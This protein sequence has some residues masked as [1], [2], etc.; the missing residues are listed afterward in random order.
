MSLL[1][2]FALEQDAGLA[3][4]PQAEPPIR[5]T[6]F[7]EN[8]AAGFR[9]DRAGPDMGSNN[10]RYTFDV[11]GRIADALRQRG[12]SLDNYSVVAARLNRQ[13]LARGDQPDFLAMMSV[14]ADGAMWRA[15]AAERKKDPAFLADL[16]DVRDLDSLDRHVVVARN[17]DLATAE[18]VQRGATGLGKAGAL[19]GGLGG[20]LTKPETF[21]PIGGGATATASVGRQILSAAVREAAANAVVTVVG[22]PL[23]GIDAERL[24][25][26]RTMGDFAADVAMS[27]GA[28]AVLGGGLK[29]VEIGARRLPGAVADTREALLGRYFDSLP[30]SVQRRMLEAGTLDQRADAA[31]V[32]ELLGADRLTPDERAAVHVLNY[33]ADVR[34]SS[35]FKPSPE[36]DKLHGQRLA[37]AID[38]LNA[39]EPLPQFTPTRRPA[40]GSQTALSSNKRDIAARIIMAESGGKAT[41]RNPVPGQSASG[42]GQF[43][44]E[45]W[46]SGIKKWFPAVARGKTD[47]Q[48]LALKTDPLLGRQ[49]TERA[50]EEYGRVLGRVGLPVTADNAY[51]IH[52]LGPRRGLA[53][54]HAPAVVEVRRL[55]PADVI[56]AN[57]RVLEGKTVGDVKAWA[58]QQMGQEAPSHLDFA[59][60]AG[61]G[62]ELRAEQFHDDGERRA[63]E[64]VLYGSDRGPFGPIHRDLAGDWSATVERLRTAG[65]GEVP[66][67][68]EHPEVGPIDVIWG[69]EKGG[70]RHVIEKHPEIVA[71]LP[72][73]LSTM[74]VV[75]R[76]PNRIQ[77]ADAEHHAT[78]RL[79]Y[80]GEQ[81]SWLLTA[82]RRDE[83]PARAEDRRAGAGEQDGS[84]A[85]GAARNIGSG[86]RRGKP[87]RDEGPTDL[88]TQIARWGGVRNDEGHDLARTGGLGNRMTRGG[89]VLTRNGLSIDQLGERL[90]EAGWFRERPEVADVL[91]LIDEAVSLGKLYRPEDRPIVAERLRALDDGSDEI[92][93]M[94]SDAARLQGVDPDP[95]LL[96]DAMA[97]MRRGEDA[98]D[99]LIGAINGRFRDEMA[100]SADEGVATP[101]PAGMM[102]AADWNRVGELRDSLSGWDDP[103]GLA[104]VDQAMSIEHDLRM[105]LEAEGDQRFLL[106][107]GGDDRSLGQILDDADKDAAAADA[108]RACLTPMN[109]AV[110]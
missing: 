36:A 57:R 55:L 31:I 39:G 33:D 25:I 84:P 2:G 58:A 59:P 86:R 97:R 45:T 101:D 38:A 49:M 3:Q 94:L 53:M 92:L 76:S 91:D 60:D 21:I 88:L 17:R 89:R 82:F 50:V 51:L 68:L 67:A 28:G 61:D 69:N 107:D 14:D 1:N 23:V 83:T 27:A 79:D 12:Y 48:L 20:E 74:D 18:E 64:T 29:T 10:A 32:P 35:P 62:V 52:F 5:E 46:L 98:D 34:E 47:D 7:L 80:D 56:A 85:L 4:L 26:D 77:L 72:E 70:L 105:A 93:S 16:V 6:G 78:V 103:D 24:G 43:I 65:T 42:L 96:A 15:L 108:M 109:G 99:A 75:Q 11:H 95:E 8:V 73:L 71:D 37:A 87:P 30:E 104:A 90:W 9:A 110:E 22:E 66:G 81:K 63:A 106:D 100:A 13:R 40:F 41:A 19:I 44:D 102:E 54:I